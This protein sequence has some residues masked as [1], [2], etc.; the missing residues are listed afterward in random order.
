MASTSSGAVQRPVSSLGGNF[1]PHRPLWRRPAVLIGLVLALL[2]TAG[3]WALWS[4]LGDDSPKPGKKAGDQA[5]SAGSVAWWAKAR[6]KPDDKVAQSL[7]TWTTSTLV[8]KA[9]PDVVTAYDI[10][11]GEKKWSF[12]LTGSLCAASRDTEGNVAVVAV[13]F[14]SHC[15]NLK[16]IDLRDG[17]RVWDE[18]LVEEKDAGDNLDPDKWGKSGPKLAVHDGHVYTAWK[19]GEQTRSLADGK[20]VDQQ[21]QN[22]CE[23]A[24]A[25]GGKQL[26]AI[27]YC[28]DREIKI[29]SLDPRKL[30]KPRWSTS[31]KR[32]DGFVSVISTDPLVLSQS[33]GTGG[34]D[35]RY[36]FVVL[37]PQSGK[38]K[39][40][41]PYNSYWRLGEC[42]LSTSGC[43]GALAD[44]DALY[45]AGQGVTM[46]YD[47]T[48]GKERWT[49]KGDA[50]RVAIPV[51]VR[52]GQ[53]AT[54]IPAT[55][56]RPGR[57][58][59]VSAATG[60]EVR[61]V[62]H[63]DNERDRKNEAVMGKA[64]GA[65]RLVND[66]LLLTNDG[67]IGSEDD[68]TIFAISAPDA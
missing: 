17:H 38:E 5:G 54:F 16:A 39:T 29:R 7:G 27:T 52:K 33:P 21:K 59:Y 3:G 28:G 51:A 14:G 65:P 31:L 48:T 42:F 23:W 34:D 30:D 32:N 13:M 47:L 64:P 60:K 56:D 50:N 35:S 2:L 49:Y 12:L 25:A 61:T 26:I 45:V 9:E 53:L 10:R 22:A 18:L 44:K 62:D 6:T 41:V 15:L 66:R 11:T 24:D 4:F 58:A 67:P 68:G 8:V 36:D 46:A 20:R 57:T 43:T 19:D 1:T 63:S 40:R 37:D 55:P